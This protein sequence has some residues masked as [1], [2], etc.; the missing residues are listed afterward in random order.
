MNVNFYND[1]EIRIRF[2]DKDIDEKAAIRKALICLEEMMQKEEE[3]QKGYLIHTLS[4]KGSTRNHDMDW[5]LD[6]YKA[7][8]NNLSDLRNLI[9]YFK[10]S[11]IK[12]PD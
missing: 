9:E 10:E 6:N 8:R 2:N 1:Q 4:K 7:S 5:Q 12:N 11:P 3:R